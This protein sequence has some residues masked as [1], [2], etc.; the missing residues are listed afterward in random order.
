MPAR[1][2]LKYSEDF[3][4]PTAI[5]NYMR[6]GGKEAEAAVR[7]EYTR[8]R[9][10]AQKRLKR[11]GE[12]M[13]ADTQTYQRNV[14][15]YPKLKDIQ[16]QSELAARLSDLSRY[17][18]AQ[19]STISGMEQQMKKSLKTLHEN[20]YMFVTRENYLD[21]GKFME[22]YRKQKLD[23]MG[24]SSGDAYDT[25]TEL[26]VHRIDPTQVKED[27]E[28]WLANRDLLKQLPVGSGKK[29]ITEKTLR[30]RMLKLGG[31]IDAEVFGATKKEIAKYHLSTSKEKRINVYN[32]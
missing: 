25:Y 7:K 30:D 32:T 12:T 4:Q 29:K 16:S 31:K 20:G 6:E 5:R 28:F 2:K 8:L 26:E 21:F 1:G 17:I 15:H 13:W 24:Y 3:Y 22:E 23:E 27:F 14:N 11:M 19:T 18:E 9:D 10:I